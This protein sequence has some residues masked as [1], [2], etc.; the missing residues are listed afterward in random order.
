LNRESF[1][2]Q[3]EVRLTLH[4][5]L[6]SLAAHGGHRTAQ[7][8][9]LRQALEVAKT[10]Y[11]PDD[12]RVQQASSELA[13]ALRPTEESV[14]LARKSFAAIERAG[15]PD[16]QEA[17]DALWR[18]ASIL[19]EGGRVDEA[20]HLLL[21]AIARQRAANAEVELRAMN[22]RCLAEIYEK[23][24]RFIEALPL[25]DEALALLENSA[26]RYTKAYWTLCE[27][28]SAVSYHL[29]LF[30]EAEHFAAQAAEAREG[31]HGLQHARTAGSHFQRGKAL[32][33]LGRYLE[34]VEVLE[35][36][37][38]FYSPAGRTDTVARVRFLQSASLL[39]AA[40]DDEGRRTLLRSISREGQSAPGNAQFD[41]LAQRAEDALR[42]NGF[43][44][45]DHLLVGLGEDLGWLVHEFLQSKKNATSLEAP[46]DVDE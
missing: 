21:N 12:L 32:H 18:L 39:A 6:A 46:D 45:D 25:I 24:K 23:E 17:N 36:A 3:P 43:R 4:E 27:R 38:A 40:R 31:A 35:K 26:L 37:L 16:T 1:D 28:R 19:Y 41:R 11:G 2:P 8:R 22:L 9:N 30:E 15:G 5:L 29:R 33:A 44:V 20:E 34:A 42:A 13:Y 7:A 10:L 14:A